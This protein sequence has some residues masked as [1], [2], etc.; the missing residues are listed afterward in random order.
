METQNNLVKE[1]LDAKMQLEQINVIVLDKMKTI[2]MIKESEEEIRQKFRESTSLWKKAAKEYAEQVKKY[3]GANNTDKY[4]GNR[5]E[6]DS[7]IDILHSWIRAISCIPGET[8]TLTRKE[9]TEIFHV[10]SQGVSKSRYE[11]NKSLALLGKVYE[12]EGC[13]VNR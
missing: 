5:P 12:P 11:R 3:P 8:I 6:L 7:K 10:A 13:M 9:W 1:L 4:P 2:E